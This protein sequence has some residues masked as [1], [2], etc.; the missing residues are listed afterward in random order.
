MLLLT[1][2]A[3]LDWNMMRRLTVGRRASFGCASQ[4]SP[5]CVSLLGTSV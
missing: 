1:V 2:S 3:G 5:A 4:V